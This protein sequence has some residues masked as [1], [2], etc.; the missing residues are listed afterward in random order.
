MILGTIIEYSTASDGTPTAA[1]R[2]VN[3][4]STVIFYTEK[5]C[6]EW[7]EIMSNSFIY[8][9]AGNTLYGLTMFLNTETGQRRWWFNG[10]EYTG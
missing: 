3:G 4:I 10:V 9:T 6:Q 5:D 7:C 1:N 8:G 2:E